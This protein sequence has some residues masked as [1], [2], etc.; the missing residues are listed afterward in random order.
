VYRA[1]RQWRTVDAACRSRLLLGL[2]VNDDDDED[3]PPAAAGQREAVL[4][5]AAMAQLAQD[6]RTGC[7]RWRW[8]AGWLAVVFAGYFVAAV[9][10]V[11][12]RG[13]DRRGPLVVAAR[14]ASKTGLV[15]RTIGTCSRRN[16]ARQP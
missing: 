13:T 11:W 15:D 14:G 5:T 2:C 4:V 7:S 6:A 10:Y 3:R 8:L 16:A 12:Q 1:G 9:P